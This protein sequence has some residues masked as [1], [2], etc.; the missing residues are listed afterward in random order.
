MS[1]KKIPLFFLLLI[2]LNILYINS[3]LNPS[4]VEIAINCGGPEFRTKSGITYQKDKYFIGGEASDFGMNSEIKNTKDKDIYQTERWS[5]EDLIY[6]IPIQNKGKYVLILKFSEVYFNSKGEKIFDFRLGDLTVLEDIDIYEKVG[7][8][9]AYDEFIEFEIKNDKLYVNGKEAKDAYDEKTKNIKLTFVK[10]EADNPKI[11]ALLIVRGT[12]KDTDYDEYQRE[13]ELLEKQKQEFDKKNR[14]FQRMSKSID[15]EDFED[16]F[17]DDGKKYRV[18]N[19]F[20]SG[21][22]IIVSLIAIGFVYFFFFQGK[23]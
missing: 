18:S 11:N 12:L 6:E 20:F 4:N 8:N 17:T 2:S 22:S 5:T 1:I 13:Q 16:D 10:K 7:K 19:G 14:E 3:K 15:F 21:K 9:R 23:R